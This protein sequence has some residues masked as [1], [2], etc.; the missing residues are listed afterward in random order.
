MAVGTGRI[1]RPRQ[2]TTLAWA[3]ASIVAS[4]VAAVGCTGGSPAP[5]HPTPAV[6]VTTGVG[7]VAAQ[8]Q[9]FYDQALEWK[10]C[11]DHPDFRCAT[12]TVPMDYAHP[13]GKDLYLSMIELPAG[14]PARRL[15]ALVVN[16]GGPG[17]SGIDYV[18]DATDAIDATV[19]ERYDIVGFDPR[20]VGESDPVHCASGAEMDTVL[21][22]DPVPTTSAQIARMSAMTK[23]FVQGC[24]TISGPEARFVGTRDAVRDMDVIRAALR[25]PKLTYLGFSYGTFLGATYAGEFP[26]HVGRMVLDGAIDPSLTPE[27]VAFPQAKSFDTNARAFLADCVRRPRCPM[28][29]SLGAATRS[30]QAFLTGLTRKPLPTIDPARPLTS[31][32]GYLGALE[33]MYSTARW[34]SLRTALRQAKAGHGDDLAALADDLTGRVGQATYQGNLEDALTAV[35]CDDVV[36]PGGLARV[37]KLADALNAKAPIFG[38]FVAWGLLGCAYWPYP[39]P[40]PPAPITAK[41]SGPIV[42]VG[43]TGDPATPYAEAVGLAKQLAEGH[44]LTRRGNGHTAYHQGSFCIDSAIDTFLLGGTI[45]PR[46]TVC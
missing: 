30:L 29:R 19:R 34:A 22:A 6:H 16:P 10:P 17:E 43:T 24:T 21:A 1:G 46:G 37:E 7:G 13:E 45:P 3:I 31:G 12:L 40:A 35:G 2:R 25:E 8:V 36:Q 15:G 18:L 33:A 44:L 9:S 23:A 11:D 42:V 26:T 39:A 38:R 14:S 41:G 27:Q 4:M 20:G 32:L 5:A 28:G